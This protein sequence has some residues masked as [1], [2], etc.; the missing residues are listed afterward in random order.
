MPMPSRLLKLETRN[1][2]FPAGGSGRSEDV[3][4]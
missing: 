2:F 4:L 3:A 1:V